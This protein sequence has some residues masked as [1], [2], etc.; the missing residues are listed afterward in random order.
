MVDDGPL[1][2]LGDRLAGHVVR[3]GAHPSGYEDVGV[4]RPDLPEAPGNDGHLVGK[5]D[6]E[7]GE[8][9]AV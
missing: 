1:E 4:R 8:D 2:G 5:G 9:A 7:L 3:G 6:D